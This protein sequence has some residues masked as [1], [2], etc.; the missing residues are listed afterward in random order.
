M[1]SP[2][3]H[4]CCRRY[5]SLAKSIAILHAKWRIHNLTHQ[6][7]P[8]HLCTPKLSNNDGS[9]TIRD[10][11]GYGKVGTTCNRQARDRNHGIPSPG[12]VEHVERSSGK[13]EVGTVRQPEGHSL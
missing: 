12:H 7:S 1:Q 10:M 2:L 5:E 4:R 11:R 3:I 9:G 13:V 8:G 6:P